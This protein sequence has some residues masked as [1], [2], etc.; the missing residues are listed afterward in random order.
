MY[1]LLYTNWRVFAFNKIA[2][3]F[4]KRPRLLR[5]F[6]WMST[7]LALYKKG[8]RCEFH[9]QGGDAGFLGVGDCPRS[10]LRT[11]DGGGGGSVIIIHAGSSL[12]M[13][14]HHHPC[15]SVII[16]TGSS[17]STKDHHHPYRIIIIHA[18]LASFMQDHHHP[19]RIIIIHA[20]SPSS[21]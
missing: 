11:A 7:S 21:M 12:C 13:Q 5:N 17:S 3:P 19:C 4:K 14:D 16:H 15:R 1:I 20:G 6:F 10:A 8:R 2:N 9:F 18:G